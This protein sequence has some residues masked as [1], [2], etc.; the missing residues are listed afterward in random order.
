MIASA[1]PFLFG[2]GFC[3]VAILGYWSWFF[4]AFQKKMASSVIAE[5]ELPP[6]SVLV[7]YKNEAQQ[8]RECLTSIV[9]QQYPS[10]EVIAMNDFSNDGSGDIVANI[11]HPGLK[12]LQASTDAPGKK[13]ALSEA[14]L[15]ASNPICLVTDADCIPASAHWIRSMAET[16]MQKKTTRI[17]LGIGPTTYEKGYLNVIERYETT[18]TA[19][20]YISY[21]VAGIPYMGVGRNLMYERSFFLEKGGFETLPGTVSGDDDLFVNHAATSSNVAINLH[22]ESFVFSAGKAT[23]MRF[24]HQKA[25]H[26]STA[27]HYK[28]KHTFFLASFAVVQVAFYGFIGLSVISADL[29]WWQAGMVVVFKWMAQ[30][31]LQANCF[32]RLGQKHLNWFFPLL[33]LSMVL[34]YLVMPLFSLRWNKSW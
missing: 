31:A 22:P 16:Y 9:A 11:N 27:P 33:D 28:A 6:V 7:C 32:S 3:L 18:L 14:I 15:A 4:L 5:S 21:A 12:K 2:T 26:I 25:R 23:L 17:V 24:L 8:I 29:L 13:K 34:Y 30:M 1:I 19:M 20:Q 10:F